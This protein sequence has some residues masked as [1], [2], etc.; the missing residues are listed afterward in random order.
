MGGVIWHNF[1]FMASGIFSFKASNM[2]YVIIMHD[3][4]TPQPPERDPKD[5]PKAGGKKS[6]P[7]LSMILLIAILLALFYTKDYLT[8]KR[9][10][11]QLSQL[12]EPKVQSEEVST[13]FGLKI[14]RKVDKQLRSLL[15]EFKAEFERV[16]TDPSYYE[17]AQPEV[18]RINFSENKADLLIEMMTT[19]PEG[20]TI[21]EDIIFV[22]DDFGRLVNTASF[23][24]IKL[25]P[26]RD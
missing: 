15:A 26:E 19:S 2:R 25:H 13:S 11:G 21:M 24:R 23:S 20:E 18:K 7:L 8:G 16:Y 5:S 17:S 3:S 12:L 14:P 4:V 22:K 1:S 10:I 9:E 6:S